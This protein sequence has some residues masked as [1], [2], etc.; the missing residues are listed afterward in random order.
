MKSFTRWRRRR[1]AS[2]LKFETNDLIW[3]CLVAYSC[4]YFH[5]STCAHILYYHSYYHITFVLLHNNW[6]PEMSEVIV[7]SANR[8]SAAWIHATPRLQDLI[9]ILW[10][11]E[12]AI[13][14]E[15]WRD[16]RWRFWCRRW[17]HWPL[18]L[19][20]LEISMITRDS[21]ETCDPCEKHPSW[22]QSAPKIS[23]WL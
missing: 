22:N 15:L 23:P 13:V 18:L 6:L 16:R 19:V 5:C 1:R 17:R 8:A 3:D 12:A 10:W 7:M 20:V 11:G 4:Y 14:E 9:A 2:C 21:C